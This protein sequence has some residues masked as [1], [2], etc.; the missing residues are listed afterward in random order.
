MNN[1]RRSIRH[2]KT[3][4]SI[5][6]GR[7]HIFTNEIKLILRSTNFEII[8]EQVIVKNGKC[9]IWLMN[10][11][12]L[13]SLELKV[14]TRNDSKKIDLLAK[15][16]LKYTGELQRYYPK[17]IVHGLGLYKCVYKNIVTD[18]YSIRTDI[19]TREI[20]DLID[21]TRTFFK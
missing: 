10:N 6:H 8:E 16:V 11:D 3:D 7:E 18:V 4:K 12:F 5:M 15:Q 19:Q 13:M 21:R 20:C 14:G 17:H 1:L 9:D 2:L